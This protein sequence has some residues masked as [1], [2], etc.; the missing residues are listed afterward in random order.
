MS[1]THDVNKY[2]NKSYK[3][4]HIQLDVVVMFE[5]IFR[6]DYATNQRKYIPQ[7]YIYENHILSPF[8][9]SIMHKYLQIIIS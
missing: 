4:R 1:I 3:S 7:I 6:E 8:V 5:I 9:P 2:F